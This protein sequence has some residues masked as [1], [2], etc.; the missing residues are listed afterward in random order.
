MS[1]NVK[2]KLDFI[3]NVIYIAVAAGII[4]IVFKLLGLIFPFLIA[5]TLVTLF[6]PLVNFIHR[7]LKINQKIISVLFMALLYIGVGSLIFWLVTRVVFL[8]KDVF[9]AFPSYYQDTIVPQLT[10]LG[11]K[12]DELLGVIPVSWTSGMDSIQDSLINGLQNM[13]ISISQK[14]IS[15]I[16]SFINAIPSFFV[17]LIFTIMLT[18]FIST[19]YDK[20][21][22]FIKNQLPEKA[23]DTL[24]NV[25][26]ILKNTV[27][28]YIKA[29][30]IL[31]IFTFIEL[32]FGFLILGLPNVIGT[33]AGIALFDALPIFGTGGIMIPWIIIEIL[34]ANYSQAIGIAILY[35]VVTLIRNIIE[36]K[37]VGDQ[38]GINPVVSLM[39]IYIG[40]RLFGVLGMIAFPM[41]AQIL[42]ALHQNGSIRLYRE[43]GKKE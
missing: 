26:T 7:K 10:N 2:K 3:I 12:L 27:F 23:A 35:G 38:L 40:Y 14:G 6:Q 30:M 34:Q 36:P 28:R 42:I 20:V 1:E 18:L 22:E 17:S 25:R 32:T 31:M 4:Y 19:Q 29:Y 16:T 13:V 41:L 39:S 21:I 8:L 5:L 37:I 15:L 9:T 11:A 43:T 33:A 24:S